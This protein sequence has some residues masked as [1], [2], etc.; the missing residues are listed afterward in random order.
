[1][2]RLITAQDRKRLIRLASG[3]PKGSEERKVILAGL[4]KA[5]MRGDRRYNKLFIGVRLAADAEDAWADW[6]NARE[7]TEEGRTAQFKAVVADTD[8]IR[9]V[10]DSVYDAATKI[11]KQEGRRAYLKNAVDFNADEIGKE[12]SGPL[13]AQDEENDIKHHFTQ[14]QFHGLLELASSMPKESSERRAILAS[15]KKSTK[16]ASAGSEIVWRIL[17]QRAFMKVW[18]ELRK[19]DEQAADLLYEVLTTLQDKLDISDSES[20]ALGRITQLVDAGS[21]WDPALQRNNIFKAANLLG[22]RLPSGM[23]A[24]TKTAGKFRLGRL[25]QTRGVAHKARENDEFGREVMDALRKYQRGDW[26]ISKDKRMNDAAVKSGDERIMG[27]YPTVEGDIWIIT[28]WDR[29]VTTVL[30]PGEY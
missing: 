5:G 22:I 17:D 8:K 29:S 30:F 19:D 4:N 9:E 26:G 13:W 28:E 6:L 16:M 11:E 20:Q 12:V 1:M 10:I 2:S 18:R 15:L 3:L 23:F 21:R 7:G 27:V 14:K 24:S 25:V